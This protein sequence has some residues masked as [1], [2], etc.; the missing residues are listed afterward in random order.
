MSAIA[1]TFA[2]LPSEVLWLVAEQLTH[3]TDVQSF[4]TTC[5]ACADIGPLC[6]VR[7]GDAHRVMR[8]RKVVLK[9]RN[10]FLSAQHVVAHV[11]GIEA[12]LVTLDF[13][14]RFYADGSYRFDSIDVIGTS[15]F[16]RQRIRGDHCHDHAT[17]SLFPHFG[18]VHGFVRT[19]YDAPKAGVIGGLEAALS[20]VMRASG[21]DV[22]R[23]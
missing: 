16:G 7:R 14:H 6:C 20:A 10:D 1:T 22:E 19:H 12:D 21:G 5:R 15:G 13:F 8:V 3:P 18:D 2:D 17:V 9:T 23:A 11:L 4:K